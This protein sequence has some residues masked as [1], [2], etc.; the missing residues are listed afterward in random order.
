MLQKMKQRST[1]N[2]LISLLT[3]RRSEKFLRSFGKQT[4][5]QL[6]TF[7]LRINEVDENCAVT[8][9]CAFSIQRTG[10]LFGGGANSQEI[11]FG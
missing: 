4:A 11:Y 10:I 8:K 3:L 6:P 7:L 9:N 2:D 5:H 1:Y